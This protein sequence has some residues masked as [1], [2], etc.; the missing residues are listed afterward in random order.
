ME[1]AMSFSWMK[2]FGKALASYVVTAASIAAVAAVDSFFSNVDQITDPVYTG[3]PFY[4][5]PALVAGFTAL[6]NVLKNYPIFK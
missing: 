2:T 5:V 6:R 3:V 1:S 4:V